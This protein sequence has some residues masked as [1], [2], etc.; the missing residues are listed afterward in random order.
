MIME[1]ELEKISR[2]EER[3][4]VL[5]KDN[6]ELAKACRH[7]HTTIRAA[8]HVAESIFNDDVADNPDVV[9]AIHAAIADDLDDVRA[10]DEDEVDPYEEED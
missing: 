3:M 1:K 4:E 9:M 8:K 5:G 10:Q 7:A 6:P 2:F